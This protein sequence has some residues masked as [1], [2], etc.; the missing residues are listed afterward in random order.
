MILSFD[1]IQ[2]IATGA[3]SVVQEPMG[4]RFYRFTQEQFDLYE[5]KAKPS[6]GRAKRPPV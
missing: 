3:V 1:Q 4:I 2:S 6:F 5:K